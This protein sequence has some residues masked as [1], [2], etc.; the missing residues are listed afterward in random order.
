[1][2]EET[3][4]AEKPSAA[5]ARELG[6]R[7]N[8]LTAYVGIVVVFIVVF[9]VLVDQRIH[10]DLGTLRAV[11]RDRHSAM[12]AARF[13]EGRLRPLRQEFFVQLDRVTTTARL[14]QAHYDTF[15]AAFAEKATLEKLPAEG[16]QARFIAARGILTQLGDDYAQ[17]RRTFEEY[18]QHAE[19]YLTAR[20]KEEKAIV[21]SRETYEKKESIPS[22]FGEINIHPAVALVLL[23]FVSALAYILLSLETRR[24]LGLASRVEGVSSSLA[25]A[26]LYS[27]DERCRT[28]FGWEGGEQRV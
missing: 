17:P 19:A 12:L 20:A 6:A 3:P 25:P 16:R 9:T 5:A 24:V 11:S 7:L 27:E 21:E 10:E 28:Y 14:P 18:E 4:M 22:P 1:M 15:E 2:D 13:E 23:A 26:W 8:K